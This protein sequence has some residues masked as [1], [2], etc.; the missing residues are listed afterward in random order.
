MLRSQFNDGPGRAMQVTVLD[1]SASEVEDELIPGF[2]SKNTDAPVILIN[3]KI[4]KKIETTKGEEGC[5]SF[6]EIY[7][8][9]PRSRDIIVKAQDEHGKELEIKATGLLSRALQHEIDHLN[10]ILYIDHISTTQRLKIKLRLNRLAK[11][12][13]K[14]Q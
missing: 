14:N 11:Q 4:V 12:T 3:P 7:V 8:N 1:L 6:P 13:R 2:Q 9:V 5:L 10:G